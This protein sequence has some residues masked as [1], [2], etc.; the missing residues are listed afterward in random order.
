MYNHVIIEWCTH[1]TINYKHKLRLAEKIS[2]GEHSHN[3]QV[4]LYFHPLWTPNIQPQE[5]K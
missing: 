4:L 5:N 1:Y 2:L 3:W